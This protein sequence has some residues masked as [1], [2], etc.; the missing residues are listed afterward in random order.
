MSDVVPRASTQRNSTWQIKRD[1]A[2]ERF[3]F[4]FEKSSETGAAE[5]ENEDENMALDAVTVAHLGAAFEIEGGPN[6]RWPEYEEHA[7]QRFIAAWRKCKETE[8]DPAVLDEL[9]AALDM[10]A[11][12]HI[13]AT[14]AVSRHLPSGVRT[15]TQ[16]SRT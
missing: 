13:A 10:L 2:I 3:V 4:A 12:A 14:S 1:K 9:N 15:P 6:K 7:T 5:D 11:V 8:E 16:L